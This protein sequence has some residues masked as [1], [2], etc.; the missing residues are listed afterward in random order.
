MRFIYSWLS[1]IAAPFAFAVVLWRGVGERCYWQSLAQRFGFGRM[2]PSRPSLWVHAVSLGEMSAAAPLVLELRDRYP[3]CALFV[4]AATPAGRWRPL[5]EGHT[6]IDS[7][8]TLP[9][10]TAIRGP[11]GLR[12]PWI[13]QLA[14]FAMVVPEKL[15]HFALGR[16]SHVYDNTTARRLVVESAPD[17][18]RES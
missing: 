17:D 16:G 2:V 5:D 11:V 8:A 14:D 7:S 18:R 10:G 3:P 4:T 6:T 15:L 9:D 13:A 1:R 12:T